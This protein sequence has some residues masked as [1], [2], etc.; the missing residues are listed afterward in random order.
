VPVA[1]VTGHAERSISPRLA[2]VLALLPPGVALTEDQQAVVETGMLET[3]G[4]ACLPTGAGKTFMAKL[5]VLLALRRGRR[6]VFLAPLRAIVRE[7]A[8]V[9]AAELAGVPRALETGEVGVDAGSESPSPAVARVILSTP[10]KMAMLVRQWSRNLDWIA[11]ISLVVVDEVHT[12]DTGRRGATLEGLVM[13]LR[14]V[15]PFVRVLGL[16]GTLGNPHELAAWLGGPAY[17][18]ARRPVPLQWEIACFSKAEQKESLT[19]DAVARVKAEGGQAIVFT[20]SRVRAERLAQRLQVRGIAAMPHHAGLSRGARERAEDAFRAGMVTALCATP[21]LAMGCNFPARLV[22]MVDLRRM[23]GAQ[24]VALL[25]RDV[26][27]QAGR[28][29]RPGLDPVGQVLLLSPKWDQVDARRYIAGRFE[30]VT[31]TLAKSDAY[32]AE[33]VMAVVGSRV[34]LRDAHVQRVLARSL[35]GCTL[36]PHVMAD[37]VDH[38]L[39]AMVRS[40]MLERD[41]DG[42]LRATRLGRIATRYLLTPATVTAWRQVE[43]QLHSASGSFAV[44]VGV[45]S[46]RYPR[47]VGGTGTCRMPTAAANDPLVGHPARQVDFCLEETIWGGRR[48]G[49]QQRAQD[50]MHWL[51]TSGGYVLRSLRRSKRVQAEVHQSCRMTH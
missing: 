49:R 6:A 50:R 45:R 33:R 23:D 21:T 28:A 3:G 2:E 1:A 51:A 29:G 4:V 42:P 39:G 35:L 34:A 32:L 10:E 48:Q 11:E 27:Q 20:Q 7:L 38:S 18:S 44:E 13:L 26:W 15:N 30:A 22:V 36:A 31:S 41:D 8:G 5:A 37:R 14:A 19:L 40:G 47:R 17:V 16:S 24:W 12:L 9:W 43:Q 25:V 46:T